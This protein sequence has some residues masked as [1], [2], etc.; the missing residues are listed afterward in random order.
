MTYALTLPVQGS[1]E[2][3]YC[4][5]SICMANMTHAAM[6]ACIHVSHTIDVRSYAH[7]FSM[8]DLQCLMCLSEPLLIEVRHS[9]SICQANL[10]AMRQASHKSCVGKAIEERCR[11]M[12][13]VKGQFGYLQAVQASLQPQH[14]QRVRQ[15]LQNLI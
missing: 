1:P 10:L 5:V 11:E 12:N 14:T 4:H 13:L 7:W 2:Q 9:H 15:T 3:A 6:S 8:T